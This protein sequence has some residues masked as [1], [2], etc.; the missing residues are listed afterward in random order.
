MPGQ[1]LMNC[2]EPKLSFSFC[3]TVVTMCPLFSE[4]QTLPFNSSFV[5]VLLPEAGR[6][7]ATVPISEKEFP[8]HP[9][10]CLHFAYVTTALLSWHQPKLLTLFVLFLEKQIIDNSW[11]IGRCYRQSHEAIMEHITDKEIQVVRGTGL[12]IV[13]NLCRHL[14]ASDQAVWWAGS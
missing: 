13:M 14:S 10:F 7:K 4:V 11:K 12:P 3:S 8:I 1:L 6:N 5:A 9:D 2:H